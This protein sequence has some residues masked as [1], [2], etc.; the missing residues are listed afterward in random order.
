MDE[1]AS[2]PVAW[3]VSA[4]PSGEILAVETG[5]G[6]LR[7]AFLGPSAAWTAPEVESWLR[8]LAGMASATVQDAMP[9]GIPRALHQA[10]SGLL[11]F[12][13]ELWPG[14]DGPSPCTLALV[15]CGDSVA[16][17]WCGGG[18]LEVRRD[19]AAYAPVWTI[20][21]DEQGRDA[22]ACSVKA[23]ARVS[24]RA[25]W[26]SG[27]GGQDVPDGVIEAHWPGAPAPADEPRVAAP[28]GELEDREAHAETATE[29]LPERIDVGPVSAATAAPSTVP[30]SHAEP[31]EQPVET[32]SG[33]AESPPRRFWRIPGWMDRLAGGEP[34]PIAHDVPGVPELIPEPAAAEPELAA[35]GPEPAAAGPEPV[36]LETTEAPV[37][38]ASAL[39]VGSA[40]AVEAS[41]S[42]AEPIAPEAGA[43]EAGRASI[44]G[45]SVV[46][47]PGIDAPEM[48]LVAAAGEWSGEPVT[49][50]EPGAAPEQQ[51][52]A[53]LHVEE[54]HDAG[55]AIAGDTAMG[56]QIP[57]AS[58][59][60]PGAA[61]PPGS[62]VVPVTSAGAPLAGAAAPPAGE[63]AAVPD[64]A[65][66]L[67]S[68][69][70]PLE[71]EAAPVAADATPPMTEAA[72]G[73]T[74]VADTAEVAAPRPRVRRPEWPEEEVAPR[75]IQPRP[76]GRI[77]LLAAALL[78]LFGGG[79]LLGRTDLPR[80]GRAAGAALQAIGLGPATYEVNVTSRPSGAWIVVDGVSQ[81]QRTP[82]T[83]RLEPGSHRVV[84][85]LS[86]QGGSSHAV[87]GKRGQHVPL[88]VELWGGLRI[89]APGAMGPVEV[90]VDGVAQGPAPV[91]LERL[92]P[93]IHRLQF[94][95]PG[96]TPWEQTVE[97]HV[98][99][100]S[101]VEAHP[102]VAPPTGVLEI[103]AA[104][105]DEAG[106]ETLRGA[107]VWI[108]GVPRGATPLRLELPS[109]PH[110]IRVSYQ[111][112][113][114]PVQVIDLPGGN[115]RFANVQIG[116]DTGGPRLS[117]QL[118]ARVPTDRPTVLSAS[119]ASARPG[120]VREM[121]LH[122]RTPEGAWRRY[123][124]T[125][126][127]AG[128][129]AV[130][131]AVFPAILFDARGRTSWYVSAL[132]P[133]GDEYFTEITAA[134]STQP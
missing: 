20:V 99:R 112:E 45:Q 49:E 126:M 61:A 64:E 117:A 73:A 94:S 87:Q 37:F 5:D 23:D 98:D 48:D 58:G 42:V 76:W 24:V 6:A 130:G 15:H 26:E 79:W 111:S 100:T 62:A 69:A 1:V 122:V 51:W 113:E 128:D 12:E 27:R 40:E 123:P 84:L 119:L 97:V 13:A 2:P 11:F 131:V 14:L 105:S 50:E 21:R 68:E 47:T 109:G 108:D 89:T 95:G 93:G 70:A 121:W 66:P 78:A 134:Q 25:R 71:R 53:A 85:S 57:P 19:G 133:T 101:E 44:P 120:D 86:G 16:I 22:R 67:V 46:A 32:G 91:L 36:R 54:D 96:I 90:A 110:S 30:A 77:A 4:R 72:P 52:S 116:L 33:V 3:N 125:L 129:S 92:P 107:A 56:E 83:L 8:E 17:G 74:G 29:V 10:L 80:V 31:P 106:T 104:L 75:A 65:A 43:A 81:S 124:M 34:E 115:V 18:S 7:V 35:A 9:E 59:S 103:R 41:V 114:A 28:Q 55:P 60:L 127:R 39:D 102:V 63:G 118:P 38:E 132:T 88:D 82:A